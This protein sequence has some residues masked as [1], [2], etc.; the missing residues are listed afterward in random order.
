MLYLY[1]N[2]LSLVIYP[3]IITHVFSFV[4]GEFGFIFTKYRKFRGNYC[5]KCPS[6]GI[7][8]KKGA[9]S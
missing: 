5:A 1:G 2:L 6:N 7:I 3:I 9:A 4:K 8:K